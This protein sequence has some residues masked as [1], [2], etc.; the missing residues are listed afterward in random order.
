MLEPAFSAIHPAFTN[1]GTTAC[2]W[3]F[4]SYR[5]DISVSNFKRDYLGPSPWLT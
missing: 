2:N 5:D 3:N 4:F 1:T